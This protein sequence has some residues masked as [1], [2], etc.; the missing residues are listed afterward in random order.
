MREVT[1][2]VFN[3]FMLFMTSLVEEQ[4]MSPMIAPVYCCLR[5]SLDKN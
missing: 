1:S 4:Y 2:G 5:K 3:E